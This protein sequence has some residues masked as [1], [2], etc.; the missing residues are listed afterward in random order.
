MAEEEARLKEESAAI[1]AKAALLGIFCGFSLVPGEELEGFPMPMLPS[2][3]Y[4]T[5]AIEDT[6]G[7]PW[8]KAK[9]DIFKEAPLGRWVVIADADVE[10]LTTA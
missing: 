4:K 6:M 7:S 5:R 3:F 10:D 8:H 9:D 2:R 1:V